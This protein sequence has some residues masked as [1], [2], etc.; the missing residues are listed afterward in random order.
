M[1]DKNFDNK[2]IPQYGS[3]NLNWYERDGLETW[4]RKNKCDN[5]LRNTD[6]HFKRTT[7]TNFDMIRQKEKITKDQRK[8]Y[9]AVDYEEIKKYPQDQQFKIA[10]SIFRHISSKEIHVS[11]ELIKDHFEK[12]KLLNANRAIGR[13]YNV[14]YNDTMYAKYW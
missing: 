4:Y 9:H 7:I 1:V 8:Q 12:Q 13:G 10:F 14:R 6:D 5:F 11:Q 3:D 2:Y